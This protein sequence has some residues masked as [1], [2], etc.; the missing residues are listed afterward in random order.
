MGNYFLYRNQGGVFSRAIHCFV[1]GFLVIA[2]TLGSLPSYGQYNTYEVPGRP[3]SIDG[4]QGINKPPQNNPVKEEENT[5]KKID[6]QPEFPGGAS[7]IFQFIRRN[8]K[9]PPQSAFI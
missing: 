5:P 9:Y 7:A 1:A 3:D 6:K 8:I 4:R 2:G